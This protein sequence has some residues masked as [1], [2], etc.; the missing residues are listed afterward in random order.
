VS[1]DTDAQ[2]VTEP[3][4]ELGVKQSPVF[5]C[6]T[7]DREASDDSGQPR[8]EIA[9]LSPGDRVRIRDTKCDLSSVGKH[10]ENS[11]YNVYRLGIPP[12]A[13]GTVVTL[14]VDR[15]P[16]LLSFCNGPIELVEPSEVTVLD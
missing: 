7:V 13:F 6:L 4:G 9:S 14:W 12:V 5:D 2:R 3:D 15:D 10:V 1:D 11:R 8:P 16:Y